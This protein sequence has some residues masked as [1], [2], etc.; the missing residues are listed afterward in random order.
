MRA[1]ISWAVYSLSSILRDQPVPISR[2]TERMVRSMLVTACRLAISPT[3]TSPFLANATTDG[4]VRPPSALAMI[5]GS[6]PSRTATAELVVPRSMPTA[7]AIFFSCMTSGRASAARHVDFVLLIVLV[8]CCWCC[9]VGQSPRHQPD[10][11]SP[12][13][14]NLRL[15]DST[16]ALPVIERGQRASTDL[17]SDAPAPGRLSVGWNDGGMTEAGR[18]SVVA[19]SKDGHHRFS[20]KPC[21][22][23]ILLEGI[24]IQGDAHAGVTVQHLHRRARHP[25]EPNL[26]Q[27]HLLPRE[28]FD[29]A[30]EEGYELAPGDLG[31]NVL[32][33]GL[34]LAGLS[35]DTLLHIGAGAVVRVTGLRSPCVQI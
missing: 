35:P 21:A 15:P 8:T 23:I 11:S 9:F 20:K 12:H 13:Y 30:R 1:L 29:E 18:A 16:K 32:T 28:F 19:V 10:L 24:G 7:R 22:Q 33:Q 17:L 5:V 26:R 31:E 3:R 6:P 14:G 27:V 2:L 4:V 34:D 25:A